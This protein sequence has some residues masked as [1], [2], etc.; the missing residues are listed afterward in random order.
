[1]P[2]ELEVDAKAP[3]EDTSPNELDA[4]TPKR[5]QRRRGRKP[6][7]SPPKYYICKEAGCPKASTRRK[8]VAYRYLVC[9][10]CYNGLR[11]QKLMALM[12][13]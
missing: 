6:K 7:A 9:M 2:M 8:G 13:Q 10:A 5:G 11:A 4:P 12:D 3:A 1:M